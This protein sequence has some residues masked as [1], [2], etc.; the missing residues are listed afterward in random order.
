MHGQPR[1]QPSYGE[2]MADAMPAHDQ[3]LAPLIM[4]T[5]LYKA[6]KYEGGGT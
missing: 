3:L 1:S 6:A 2:G 5:F 4:P